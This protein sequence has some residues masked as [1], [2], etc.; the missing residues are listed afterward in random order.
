MNNSEDGRENLK[1]YNLILANNSPSYEVYI[2]N[3]LHY[4]FTDLKQVYVSDSPLAIPLPYLGK[5]D[6][7]L[8]KNTINASMMNFF[9]A[10]LKNKQFQKNTY[11]I[12]KNE[13]IFINNE[14]N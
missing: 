3:S 9:D 13:V 4:T 14:K 5:V 7:A 1:I 12:H 10:A 8:V 2:K 11:A 6:K